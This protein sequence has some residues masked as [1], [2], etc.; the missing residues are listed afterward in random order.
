MAHNLI[1][2]PVAYLIMNEWLRGFAYHI[3]LSLWMFAAA[4]GLALFI[5]LATVSAQSF[6][7]AR[8]NPV[9]ALRYE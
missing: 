5:A 7:T 6:V 9:T 4:G 8:A 3:D 1:A 2:W